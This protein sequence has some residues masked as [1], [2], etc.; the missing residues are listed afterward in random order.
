MT[1]TVLTPPVYQVTCDHPGCARV[2]IPTGVW[3]TDVE[4]ARERA[5]G[6]GWD[7]ADLD[8][9]PDHAEGDTR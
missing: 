4:L 3:R 2:F 5:T 7:C 1:V 6:R 8:L 9:C